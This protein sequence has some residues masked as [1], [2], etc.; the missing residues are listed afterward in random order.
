[1]FRYIETLEI[2]K[3]AGCIAISTN[4]CD[5]NIKD[6]IQ[7]VNDDGYFFG[8]NDENN[9]VIHGLTVWLIRKDGTR[10]STPEC[11]GIF[12]G[13]KSEILARAEVFAGVVE[14]AKTTAHQFYDAFNEAF[15][16]KTGGDWDAVAFDCDKD[17]LRNRGLLITDELYSTA[18]SLYQ[19]VFIAQTQILD[20]AVAV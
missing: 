14:L 5:I 13:S 1:M 18:W 15:D 12:T 4:A 19:W 20:N 10:K 16:A 9:H 2:L 6:A 8:E 7:S 3:A 17:L 11:E